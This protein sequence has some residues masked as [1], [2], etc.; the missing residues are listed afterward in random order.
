MKRKTELWFHFS[1]SGIASVFSFS[2][3]QS[4]VF[5]FCRLP[6]MPLQTFSYFSWAHLPFSSGHET[7][8]AA[9]FGWQVKYSVKGRD[10]M[11]KIA[12]LTLALF[13]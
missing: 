12:N 10:K 9:A 2:F 4:I 13:I 7:K 3:S 1:I 8:Q 6:L 5:P 11:E